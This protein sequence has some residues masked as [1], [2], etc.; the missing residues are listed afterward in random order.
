MSKSI[1]SWIATCAAATALAL[2]FTTP[3]LAG[4][5]QAG[6]QKSLVCSACHGQD[7]NSISPEWP[8]L[9][10]QN[11]RYTAEQMR[12]FR[13]GHRNNIVMAAQAMMLTDEDIA[14]LSAYYATLIPAGLEADPSFYKAGEALYRAGDR[15]RNIPS[16]KG[17]HGP[18]GDGNPAAG[19]PA[20]RAQHSMYTIMQ[21]EAYAN[22]Q[23]YLDAEGNKQKSL[24]GHMM[25]TISKRLTEEDRRNLASY[26][27]GMR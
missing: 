22:E 23:R 7:G 16:C 24:N 6:E 8:S 1:V 21:L 15:L 18:V 2:S 11:A 27:Q 26:I 19:Y 10:G 17:C 4:D 9:A 20:L 5:P 14:D 13:S 25:T 3:A 12:L